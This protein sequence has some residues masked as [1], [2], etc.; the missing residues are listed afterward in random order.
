V[1]L[2]WLQSIVRK[3]EVSFQTNYLVNLIIRIF[4]FKCVYSSDVFAFESKSKTKK[5]LKIFALAKVKAS[6]M[7]FQ[8]NSILKT[9]IC[10]KL[11]IN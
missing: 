8:S 6:Q 2:Y 10:L 9:A 5:H 7:K 11:K 4:P 3:E 1:D